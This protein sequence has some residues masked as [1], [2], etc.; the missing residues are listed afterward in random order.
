MGET[1]K[2]KRGRVCIDGAEI[3]FT[4]TATISLDAPTLD[5]VMEMGSGCISLAVRRMAAELLMMRATAR[6]EKTSTP[7][8]LPSVDVMNQRIRSQADWMKKP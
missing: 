6:G 8:K 2:R 5:M 3:V 1:Y 4:T 7:R